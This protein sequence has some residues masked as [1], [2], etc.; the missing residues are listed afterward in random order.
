ML[1]ILI[2]SIFPCVNLKL[3]KHTFEIDYDSGSPDGVRNN[4][5]LKINQQFPGPT[6]IAEE[7]DILQ[8]DVVNKIR[9][10]QETTIHWH[11]IHQRGTPFEDGP[12]MVT[13]CAI[14]YNFTQRYQFKL[15]QWGTFWYI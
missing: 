8:V 2:F 7:G 15:E 9:N 13:Q 12:N 11:G 3:V 14:R 6:I 5:I 4:W 10:R 1:S